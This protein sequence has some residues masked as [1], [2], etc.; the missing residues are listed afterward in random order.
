MKLGKLL[1]ATAV[2]LIVA[3][4]AVAKNWMWETGQQSINGSITVRSTNG[5]ASQNVVQ[6]PTGAVAKVDQSA[7]TQPPTIIVQQTGGGDCYLVFFNVSGTPK[8]LMGNGIFEGSTFTGMLYGTKTAGY[9][10]EC[11]TDASCAWN[12][13]T[14]G[15]SGYGIVSVVGLP[16]TRKEAVACL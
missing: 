1:V 16:I 3:V 15:Y 8:M 9:F 7:V 13:A 5:G 10:R 4:P 12:S 14:Y 2:A 11:G 6:N